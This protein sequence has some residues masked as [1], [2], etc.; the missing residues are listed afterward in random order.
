[1]KKYRVFLTK[2]VRTS[3]VVEVKDNQNSDDAEE[4]VD[5]RKADWRV[6]CGDKVEYRRV[7]CIEDRG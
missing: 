1:M 6:G 5:A 2:T 4:L 3:V 7:A